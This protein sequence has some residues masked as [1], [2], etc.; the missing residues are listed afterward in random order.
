MNHVY[1]YIY[2]YKY[3]NECNVEPLSYLVLLHTMTT[4]LFY[5]YLNVG[6]S[7]L[8]YKQEPQSYKLV[9]RN[10]RNK[11]HPVL[12]FLEN[13]QTMLRLAMELID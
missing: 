3:I 12:P 10:R 6:W 9:I 5:P 11:F 13:M 2:I 4:S 8:P 7:I 1:I